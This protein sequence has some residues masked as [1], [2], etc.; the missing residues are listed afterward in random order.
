MKTFFTAATTAVAV[1][2]P[3]TVSDN[4]LLYNG[5]ETVLH[6]FSTTC[7][8]YL[9]R[10]IGMDCWASYDW[11]DHTN[12]ITSLDSGTVGAVKGYFSQIMSDG[13]KPAL[14]LPMTASY[15]LGVETNAAKSNMK[16][17]PDLSKQY[18]TMIGKI[19]DE[20]T[21][22]G[23]VVILDLQWNDDDN[24]QTNMPLRAKSGTGGSV[25]FW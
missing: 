20:I 9:L 25:E 12:I 7:T 16:K 8:E 22:M 4:K 18:Q 14:R 13:V 1:A 3:W 11:N 23:G 6:G 5:T 24:E 2:G 17:Y 19:V 21:G 15:W 10:G